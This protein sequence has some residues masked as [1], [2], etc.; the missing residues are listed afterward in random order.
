MLNPILQGLSSCYTCRGGKMGTSKPN[1]WLFRHLLRTIGDKSAIKRTWPTS[2][3]FPRTGSQGNLIF[4]ITAERTEEPSVRREQRLSF[5]VRR[6]PRLL[7]FFQ[8]F[9][10]VLKLN[11]TYFSELLLLEY[12]GAVL[13]RR[14]RRYSNKNAT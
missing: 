5:Y 10:S 4:W 3:T 8:R 14:I 13:F 11:S 7:L 2:E 1:Y 12:P 9:F 6:S